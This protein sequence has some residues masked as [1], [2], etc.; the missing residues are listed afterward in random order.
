V[1]DSARECVKKMVKNWY[2]LCFFC[3]KRALFVIS[4][5]IFVFFVISLTILGPA[6]AKASSRQA[7]FAQFLS[8]LVYGGEAFLRIGD[9]VKIGELSLSRGVFL[10]SVAFWF[11][12]VFFAKVAQ[13][14]SRGWCE[15][16]LYN[17]DKTEKD[18]DKN[19]L[20]FE[21]F[22]GIIPAENGGF[23]IDYIRMNNNH[24]CLDNAR[25]PRKNLTMTSLFPTE[26]SYL[27]YQPKPAAHFDPE[28]IVLTKNSCQTAQQRNFVQAICSLYPKAQVL[29]RF[30]ISH[31]RFEPGGSDPLELHYRGKKT[32][33]FGVHKSALRFSDEDGNS[34]PNYWH[35]SPYG[36]CPYDCQYCYLAGTPGVKFS[37]TVKIFV[38]IDEILDQ[39][40]GAASKLSEPT[41]FY[42][43]KLQDGLALDPLTG[44]SRTLITFFARQ[45]KARLTLL[46]K[47]SNVDNLLD[48]D[49]RGST[50][51]S[52]SL[53]PPD[54]SD[55]FES[56]VPS[57]D[58]RINAM[59]KCADVGYPL[60]AVIMPIIPVE[61]WQN[62]YRRFLENLLESVPLGRITLGQICS[63]SGALQLTERK[64]GK[65]N[66]ITKMLEKGK[67][68]D[69]R[70]RFPIKTRIKV[71]R[72]LVDT[73]GKLQP[74]LQV[75]LCM[76]E[77][78]AFKALDMED[79]IG[80]CN[81]VL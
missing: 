22:S 35:F 25:L 12:V 41:A 37:P 30:D 8:L 24:S 65:D 28:T 74:Q 34:C 73:I 2:F 60:R 3:K 76:E 39:I 57:L 29:E 67:S 55:A 17:P 70:T 1:V 72:Y 66:P 48:L 7:E 26:N 21:T 6:F 79:S 4:C 81:C 33:V 9:L 80:C 56:N 62:I 69:G 51:L 58:E 77:A 38:N 42:L 53:N 54:I 59:R 47:S 10:S 11:W 64:L 61:G 19:I 45:R 36:F 16:E 43:G 32:L 46:T 52:W 20:K 40:A 50:I 14:P 31:N 49:H 13:S 5:A 75:G 15:R 44:Y 18:Y 27:N 78:E 63:Y 68:K 71:Y 23:I